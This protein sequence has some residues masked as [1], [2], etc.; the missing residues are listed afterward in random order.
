MKRIAVIGAGGH[1]RVVVD[2]A[3][4]LGLQIIGAADDDPTKRL[5]DLPHLGPPAALRLEPGVVA[6][7]AIGSNAVRQRLAARLTGLKWDSLVHPHAVVSLRAT[8]QPGAVVFAGAV[9]QADTLIGAHA[10]VNTAASVDHDCQVGAFA[11]IGPGA[12]LAGGVSL[13]EGA[14]A[15]AG[16]VVLPGV[17]L[18]AWCTLGAGGV[19][20]RNVPPHEVHAG[21]P[22]RKL[23]PHTPGSTSQEKP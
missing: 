13:E 23:E 15:G 22:A 17:R 9:V 5:Y 21:V 7:L 10:I 12:V 2:L 20:A 11:H 3:E 1:A 4:M 8:V 14:F 19:A 16:S 6:V 18:G